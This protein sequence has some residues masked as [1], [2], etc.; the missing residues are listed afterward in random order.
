[1]PTIRSTPRLIAA[2]LLA[3][4]LAACAHDAASGLPKLNVDPARVAVAGLSSGAYMA[5][6]S[7]MAWPEIFSGAA[8][9]SGGPYGC[10]GGELKTALSSCMKGAP[11]P[12]VDA[13]VAR[14]RDR[15]RDGELGRLS[16]LANSHVYVLHGKADTL[17]AETVAR[18][19]AAFYEKL[20]DADAALHSLKVVWDGDRAFSHNLPV[21]AKG[22]DCEKSEAPYLGHCGF[23]A[24]AKIFAELFGD[25]THAAS[26]AT[27]ELRHFDQK[28][29]LAPGKDAFLANQGYAYLPKSCLAGKSCGVLVVFHGC[30]QNADAV[31]E[32]F[33]R[34]AGFNR[35]ADVYNVAVLYPQTRASFAPLNPQ[36]CWDWWGYS[37][38]GYDTRRGV[39][40]Q[41]LRRALTALGV[42]SATH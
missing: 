20:R 29:F 1:M 15:A 7:H 5:T 26:T 33:V 10:A 6:Q 8:L 19:T 30:K 34:G 9:V 11:P 37:G 12:D 16:A 24:A 41:W 28:R 36:A 21:A 42:A 13:L 3:F 22:D 18:D 2:V 40:Q 39:Q 14:A 23:D 27:G 25:P 31:G 32:T 17:V 38:T 4:S 35:W